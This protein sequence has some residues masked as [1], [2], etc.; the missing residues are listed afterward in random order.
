MLNWDNYE[1][2][3]F[4]N[5][6]FI[7]P[8]LT[9]CPVW[10]NFAVSKLPN[11]V[12]DLNFSCFFFFFKSS[13]QGPW[14]TRRSWTSLCLI[15]A[16]IFQPENFTC[17]RSSDPTCKKIENII[18]NHKLHWKLYTFRCTRK[19]GIWICINFYGQVCWR[20]LQQSWWIFG[21]STK[22]EGKSGG[23]R[24]CRGLLS[25]QGRP[26]LRCIHI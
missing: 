16:Q 22:W 19:W 18:W 1:D 25:G 9:P 14:T 12:T 26:L 15:S 17:S 4:E 10:N 6:I 8:H 24:H 13:F 5:I 20:A 11:F 2:R 21:G 3:W 23:C 7:T